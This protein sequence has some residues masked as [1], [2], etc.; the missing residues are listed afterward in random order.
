MRVLSVVH[1]LGHRG[2]QRAAQE[3]A[4]GLARRGVPVAVFAHS[5]GGPRAD[6]LRQAG[7]SVWISDNAHG[8]ALREAQEFKA[9][10]IHI[11]RRG[12]PSVHEA[13]VLGA[14]KS[15]G[16][17]TLETN[18][19]GRVDRSASGRLIDIH[20]H[21]SKWTLYR[22]R[23]WAGR[24]CPQPALVLSYPVATSV[25]RPVDDNKSEMFRSALNVP[26]RPFV[27]GRIGK[28]DPALFRAFATLA[29][30]R[31]DAY[32]LC[33]D[34]APDVQPAVQ[35]FIPAPFRSRVHL[36]P[37]ML[38]D[39]Q[40]RR[41]YCSLDC[42]LHA[43]TIGETFGMVMAEAMACGVPVVTCARPHKDNAQCE[44]VGPYG[45]VAGSLKGMPKALSCFYDL[46][47]ANALPF[48][49]EAIRDSIVQRYD[50]N[51]VISRFLEIAAISLRSRD[52]I[53]ARA[54]LMAAP[55]MVCDVSRQEARLLLAMCCTPTRLD[56]RAAMHVIHNPV[57]YAAYQAARRFTGR[58]GH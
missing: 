46:H 18:V 12:L 45:V 54:A 22:W 2:T 50:T 37:K 8:A 52:R 55:D 15:P 6:I 48:T 14:L 57:A 1:D 43:A 9:D 33:V 26:G 39:E 25:F 51:R 3:F 19:F 11:H 10:I 24:S 34:D 58:A 42:L 13:E 29:A 40:L 23:K 4:L 5:G 44:V 27:C 16:S 32:L 53:S 28:W 47:R 31:D 21:L 7:I 41:F 56:E 38:D 30:A 20:M 49:A 36:L 17:R 35:R